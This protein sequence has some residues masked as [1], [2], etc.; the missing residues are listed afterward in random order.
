MDIM[1]Q[2]IKNI[3]KSV[4]LYNFYDGRDYLI[5]RGEP[6]QLLDLSWRPFATLRCEISRMST[7]TCLYLSNSQTI[8]KLV[9]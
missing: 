8:I 1:S 6:F 2:I 9:K 4:R 7:V 5:F 3:V